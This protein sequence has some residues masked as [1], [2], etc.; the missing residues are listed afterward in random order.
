M[1]VQEYTQ[2]TGGFW[3]LGNIRKG[4]PKTDNAPGQDLD[5]FRMTY[6]P[7]KKAKE[8]EAA[9][10]AAY[11]P[12]PTELNI[13]LN[14]LK[15][16]DVWDVN[17]VCYKQGGLYATVGT[18]TNGPYWIFRRDFDT[19]EVLIRHGSPVN[20]EGRALMDKPIDLSAPLY[21]N[22]KK[23]HKG[24]ELEGRLQVVIHELAHIE[25]G[26]F[27]FVPGSPRDLGNVSRELLA[28]EGVAKSFGKTIN[29][30]PFRL[31][32]REEEV[33]KKI[34][35]KLVRGP[36]WVVHL[37]A[38]GEYGKRALEVIER[39][40]LPDVG[41]GEVTEIPNEGPEWDEGFDEPPAPQIPA[42]VETP[43]VMPSAPTPPALPSTREA[44]IKI[45][46]DE[47]NAA[48]QKKV[49]LKSIPVINPKMTPDQIKEAIAGIRA[50]VAAA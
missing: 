28:Y 43:K 14:G 26:Y 41:E 9:F 4:A 5:H 32:R 20:A 25:V 24:L 50:A 47:Y 34:K 23:E 42:T 1:P 18:N 49:N 19:A 45:F 2:A 15:V 13:R 46:S 21:Y 30:V 39:L 22:A 37:T 17:Y 10:L 29:G 40:A 44:L 6:M 38:E 31:V 48:S 27:E 8:L 7:G 3:K 12:K 16:S 36:S 33:P 11:G 35:G